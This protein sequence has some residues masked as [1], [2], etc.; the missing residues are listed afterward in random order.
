MVAKRKFDEVKEEIELMLNSSVIWDILIVWK[1]RVLRT[2][3][4][5]I[6]KILLFSVWFVRKLLAKLN[7][8]R[9]DYSKLVRY[10]R[11]MVMC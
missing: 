9:R 5:S 4:I 7:R 10:L 3:K 2:K 6:R 8:V 1:F 11:N